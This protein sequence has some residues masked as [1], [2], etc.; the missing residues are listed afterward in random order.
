VPYRAYDPD[1]LT[2][3]QGEARLRSEATAT[4]IY[5]MAA[6][7]QHWLD[8]FEEVK[9]DLIDEARPKLATIHPRAPDNIADLATGLFVATE[10]MPELAE[11]GVDL[12]L[13]WEQLLVLG[14]GQQEHVQEGDQ[15]RIF[16]DMIK[17]AVSSKAAYLSPAYAPEASPPEGSEDA[18]GWM[19]V[20]DGFDS[21]D[22]ERSRPPKFMAKGPR[23]GWVDDN[24]V[25]LD[26][27]A[28]YAAAE[29]MAER[30]RTGIGISPNALW[31]MLGEKGW[32]AH[33]DKD[34]NLYKA[35]IGGEQQRVIC[36]K[37]WFGVDPAIPG[38]P[39]N[40]GIGGRAEKFC[41]CGKPA[42]ATGRGGDWCA[43]HLTPWSRRAAAAQ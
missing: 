35:T 26:P 15:S 10:L 18:W 2:M 31:R 24:L 23:I 12:D 40:A 17:S 5:R 16:L 19:K 3:A 20:D 42:C 39:A 9:R 8:R 22:P 34:R 21:P 7:R 29:Q 33:T 14:E 41:Y 27:A 13:A 32:L 30:N 1:T 38:N 36:V 4:L 28:A 25:Y 43:D 11:H 6:D 37:A